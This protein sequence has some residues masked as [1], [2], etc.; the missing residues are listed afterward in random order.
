MRTAFGT[1]ATI[2]VIMLVTLLPFLPG[3]YDPLALPLSMMARVLG[4]AGLLLV[5]I[6]A[7]W[8][9][10]QYA[11]PLA[12][13]QHAFAVAA[14]IASSI[15]WAAVTLAAF[16]LGSASLAAITAVLGLSVFA[17]VTRRLRAERTAP[18]ARSGAAL[19][20]LVVPAAV[21]LLQRA[22]LG[23]VVEFSRDRAI[24]NSAPMI[25]AI[26]QFR[27]TRGH[28]PE[29]LLSVQRDYSPGIIGIDRY[30]YEPSGDAFNLLFEQPTTPLG[31]QEIVV[32]NPRDG[33]TATG[34]V[35]DILEFTP[36]HLERTRGFFSSRG[37]PSLGL[38]WD[39]IQHGQIADARTQAESLEQRVAAL[40]SELR[41]TNE[42]LVKLCRALEKRFGE[43]LDGD[44]RVG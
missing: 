38:I 32:Y 4:L 42:A 24:R 3:P 36:E 13:K 41:R 5:P 20:L 43:D 25:A 7:L 23:P 28:Y 44:K 22:V 33:Q 29:S 35:L 16:A 39:I 19:F 30:R 11:R 14:L 10:A 2:V 31:T 8:T 6:G 34:H 26:E 12:G 1:A 27:A 9:A 40:E 17:R 37:Q 15:V 21:F 18:P